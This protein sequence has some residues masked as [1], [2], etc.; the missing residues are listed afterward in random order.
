[1]SLNFLDGPQM[2]ALFKFLD[3]T[4]VSIPIIIWTKEYLE[5]F[6]GNKFKFRYLNLLA[7][8]QSHLDAAWR[9][10]KKQTVL[11][12]SATFKK[13]IKHIKENHRFTFAQ[14]SPAYYEWMKRHYPDVYNEIKVQVKNG[15]WI[16]M[17]GMWVEPD[18]NLPSGESLVRQ[19]LYGMRFFKKEF[20]KMP[21]IEFLQDTFGFSWS[22]P[23]ILVKSGARMFGTG[24]MF[25]NDTNKFP[26]GMFHWR[27]PDGSSIPTLLIHF[28]YFLPVIYGKEYPNIYRLTKDTVKPGTFPMFNYASSIKNMREAQSTELMRNMIFGYGLGDGG[29][30]PIEA[31]LTI[32]NALKALFFKRF[33]FCREGD[34]YK[35]FLP[36]FKRW[37][38]WNDELYLELHRGVFTTNARTKKYNRSLE[39]MLE[40][41]EKGCTVST[42]LGAMYPR[43]VLESCWKIVLFNQF[44]DILPGSSIFEV[45]KDAFEEYEQ[46]SVMLGKLAS[47][48]LKVMAGS[49]DGP[50]RA[51]VWN[52]LS[53]Q[54]D[55]IA[56][57]QPGRHDALLEAIKNGTARLAVQELDDGSVLARVQAPPLGF[58][59]IDSSNDELVASF[60]PTVVE[61]A[62]ITRL[63][64]DKVKVDVD[65]ATGYIT[66]LFHKEQAH[67]MAAGACNK[68][69]LFKDE[70]R[71]SD[72]WEID[73]DYLAKQLDMD[74][75]CTR[76][77]IIE[78]GPLRAGIEVEHVYGN[79]K[80]VQ[81]IFIQYHDELVRCEMDVDWQCKKTLFKL[82]FP[83][84][85]KSEIIH[86]EIPYAVI[87]RPTRPRTVLDKARWEYPCQ[88]W[89]DLSDGTRGVGFVNDSKY[90]FNAI[91]SEVRMTMLNGPKYTG[92]AKET[93]FVDRDDT[94]MPTHVDQF[95]HENIVYGLFLHA[96]DWREGTWKKAMEVNT[97]VTVFA[98]HGTKDDKRALSISTSSPN[99]I[100]TA[101][102]VHEDEKDLDSPSRH[103]MRLV[104]MEGRDTSDVKVTMKGFGTIERVQET[105]LL[106]LEEGRSIDAAGDSFT[107]DAGAHEIKTVVVKLATRGHFT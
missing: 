96:S 57:L 38:T 74:E 89:I 90:G 65:K 52:P 64:N 60:K 75:K 1:M 63:E 106:E 86:S 17:G 14:T 95:F 48:T 13:A 37:P 21:D 33:H 42:F 46:A 31:E 6:M 100:V 55:E 72:A 59:G 79:T 98:R 70:P 77:E 7:V 69:M 84:T 87:A 5:R 53:W 73:H 43:D 54:R 35:H 36:F 101:F 23:Q 71:G 10:R 27:A 2:R 93:I 50:A 56:R 34:F 58:A 11:K 25:W 67:E 102:K 85:I 15:R 41:V 28:G 81:R 22:L 44:H 107:L 83:T 82:A 8:G 49:G 61:R 105:N 16:L 9:W 51:M 24:K 26:L 92:Y 80:F 39:A 40:S 29:H 20:G 62:G 97:P 94:T 3:I 76:L 18:L 19:R 103:V 88:R 99:V 47:D 68:I 45:Y 104:E 91:D 4:K 66:S 12:A 32:V 30:G 78:R